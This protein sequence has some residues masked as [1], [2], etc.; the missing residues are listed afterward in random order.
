M[1]DL[2]GTRLLALDVDGVLTDGGLYYGPD[3]VVLRFSAEDGAGLVALREMDYSVALV[4]FRDFPAARRRAA[5]L[6][7]DLLCLGSADKESALR[8]LC[9][10]LSISCGQALFMGDGLMDLPAIRTAGIGA[11]P[12]DAH[13][14]VRA[15][16]DIVTSRPGGR[17]AVREVADMILG[18]TQDG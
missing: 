8:K 13:P 18:R 7:I 2:S 15:V 10:L 6:G 3:G 12:C 9:G 1:I 14:E 16:C 17:G 4:S 11:C 5:D